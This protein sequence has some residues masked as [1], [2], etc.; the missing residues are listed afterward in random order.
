VDITL[1]FIMLQ[2]WLKLR[3]VTNR[4][5]MAVNGRDGRRCSLT[6]MGAG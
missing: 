3:V 1:E 5:N 6:V 4:Q 2:D